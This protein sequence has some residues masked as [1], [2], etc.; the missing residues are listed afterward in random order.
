MYLFNMALHDYPS[1]ISRIIL[2]INA[3][4]KYTAMFIRNKTLDNI[5][6]VNGQ[7]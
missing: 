5:Y 6:M 7:R 4:S 3:A 2:L 1:L